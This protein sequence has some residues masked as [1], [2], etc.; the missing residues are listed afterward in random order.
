[1]GRALSTSLLEATS[2]KQHPRRRESNRTGAGTLAFT[3]LTVVILITVYLFFVS[4]RL[5]VVNLGYRT[6]EALR[7]QKELLDVNT[8]LKIEQATLLSPERI[9]SYGREKLGMGDPGENQ[10]RFVP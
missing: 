8:K 10:V 3:L 5:W 4:S 9:D 1:M 7:E 6:S 2:W